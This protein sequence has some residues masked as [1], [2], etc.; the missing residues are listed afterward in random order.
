MRF[1]LRNVG[2]Q[3]D[4]SPIPA[5]IYR[6]KAK[7]KPGGVGEH[8]L[9]RLAK[10]QRSEMLDLELTVLGGEFDGRKVWDL[11]TVYANLTEDDITPA[12]DAEQAQRLESGVRRGLKRLK[13]MLESAH[14][15]SPDDTSDEAQRIRVFESL[16]IFDGL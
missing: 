8:G 3:V 13:A 12:V 6:L 4:F 11:V 15:V 7:I 9:L 1:D 14:E 2:K 10:N 16:R 5:G